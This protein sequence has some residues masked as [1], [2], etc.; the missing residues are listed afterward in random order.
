MLVDKVVQLGSTMGCLVQVGEGVR[1][2]SCHLGDACFLVAGVRIPGGVYD[3]N[4]SHLS[5]NSRAICPDDAVRPQRP[6]RLR[7]PEE[8]LASNRLQ[9]TCPSSPVP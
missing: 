3:Q 4:S 8:I 6:E 1:Q 2:G 7:V 5:V 9:H